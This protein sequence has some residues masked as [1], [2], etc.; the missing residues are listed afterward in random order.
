MY[1]DLRD[2]SQLGLISL[3]FSTILLTFSFGYHVIIKNLISVLLFESVWSASF[4]RVMTHVPSVGPRPSAW[5]VRP[6]YK[7]T[8]A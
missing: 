4:L 1:D 8:V 5:F 3:L 6:A 7:V 2:S